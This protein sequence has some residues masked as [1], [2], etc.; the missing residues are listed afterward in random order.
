[1]RRT[2][3][4]ATVTLENGNTIRCTPDHLF[5]CGNEWVKAKDLNGQKIAKSLCGVHTESCC[6][7]IVEHAEEALNRSNGRSFVAGLVTWFIMRPV[8]LSAAF[9]A[10]CKR[11]AGQASQRPEGSARQIADWLSTSF[12]T[13]LVPSVAGCSIRTSR[14]GVEDTDGT[15][16]V[17]E[18]VQ[19]GPRRRMRIASGKSVLQCEA[20]S[21]RCG[22]VEVGQLLIETIAGWIGTGKASAQ[23]SETGTNAGDAGQHKQGRWTFTTS[24]LSIISRL[25]SKPT[26]F[27]TSNLCAENATGSASK[28]AK[29]TRCFSHLDA[30]A[31]GTTD[32]SEASASTRRNSQRLTFSESENPKKAQVRLPGNMELDTL[33]SGLLGTGARGVICKSVE[34]ADA[35]CDVFDL[36]VE[37]D[38]S[39]IVADVVAHNCEFCEF[40][41]GSRYDANYEPMDGGPELTR[42]P[43]AHFSCRCKLIE[44]DLEADR[45]PRA[46]ETKLDGW[47]KKIEER[48]PGGNKATFGEAAAGAFERGDIS[49]AEMM[50]SVRV[51]SPDDFASL[52]SDPDVR[53]M[54]EGF[55]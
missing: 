45:L 1:V 51:L 36:T 17:P 30:K 46:T 16:H 50:K 27:A 42:T 6:A 21:I 44:L 55:K 47:F 52:Q 7:P 32:M 40:M 48:S 29:R 34:I 2:S 11:F 19:S 15:R 39:F 18:S 49:A 23:G 4:L 33:A 10:V 14:L 12:Q 54:L 20:Q 37:H 43:P 8:I 13:G 41:D 5:L 26:G 9:I 25:T 3:Q 53:A 35:D 24:F 31:V 28:N 38:H 22:L